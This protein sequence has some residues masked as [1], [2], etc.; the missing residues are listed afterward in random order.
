MTI[1]NV[2]IVRNRISG[3]V[4]RAADTR[5]GRRDFVNLPWLVHAA[6]PV[7]R[8]PLRRGVADGMRAAS[9]P[10]HTEA[11]IAHFVAYRGGNEPVGRVAVT[12]DH[13]YVHRYGDYGFFGFFDSVDDVGV[14]DALLTT[15][16][17]WAGDRGA[18][19]LTGPYSYSP[20]HEM[21]LLVDGFDHSPTVMQP[22][23]PPY[24]ATLLEECGFRRRFDTTTYRWSRETDA[25]RAERLVARAEKVL[26]SGRIRVRIPDMRRYDEELEL[27][28]RIYNDSFHDHPEH[29]PI[30]A[31]VFG[32]IAADLKPVLDPELI[33]IVE[34]D[35]TACG[36]SMLVPDLN[37]VVPRSGRLTL[38]LLA[39]L[40]CKNDN[41]IRGV[42]TAVVVMIGVAREQMGLGAGRVV[43]GE[44]AKAVLSGRYRQ[45][46]T[47]WIHEHNHWSKALV[48]QM[49]SPP[50]RR[51]R[52]YERAIE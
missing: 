28:R 7:W 45:V 24:Y 39:R 47:T 9:N 1:D 49:K 43:A 31:P 51:Y 29:V 40:L 18:S 13:E 10:F 23:N 21:G 37:E 27:L 48:A 22:H 14:A 8:P 2:E 52:V 36:F 3:L 41:R 16:R 32:R 46:T 38:P 19:V 26:A 11:D 33:R 35:G 34:I 25:E 5:R 20:R 4:V 30:S 17:R 44:I 50:S 12:I 42:D 6:D 15:A